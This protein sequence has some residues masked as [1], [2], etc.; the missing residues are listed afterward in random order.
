MQKSRLEIKV[1]LFVLIGLAL[2]AVLL[3]QFSKGT[4]LFRG[5]YELRLHAANVGGIKPRAGVLLAGV[6]IGTVTDIHLDN[7]GTNVTMILKIYKG[8]PIYHDAVFVIEQSGFLGDQLCLRQPDDQ[9]RC[10]F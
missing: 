1:G 7:G 3:L 5:T 2:L 4:S 6:Q 10:R 8:Y 9:Y